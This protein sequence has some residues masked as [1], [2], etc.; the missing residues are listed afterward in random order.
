MDESNIHGLSG[1]V[2]FGNTCYMNTAIQCVCHIPK[3]RDYFIKKTF[4]KDINREKEEIN[5]IIEWYKLLNGLWGQNCVI[6]PNTFRQEVR[7]LAFKQ[8]VNLNLVGNGQN[9][10]QEFILFL[11]SS[12]HNGLSKK[13]SMNITGKI[14]NDLDRMAL[15]AFKS[16]KLFFKDD[17][18]FLVEMFYGQHTSQIYSLD[19]KLLSTTYEPFCYLTL[20]IPDIVN[21]NKNIEIEDCLEQYTKYEKLEGDNKWF[22]E[23]T[24][25]YIE[26]YKQIKFWSCPKVL[27]IVLKRFQNNG[28]KNT[29]CINFPLDNLDLSKYCLGYGANKFKYKL[30]SISNHM[31]SLSGGH[32]F[33]YCLNPTDDK[34]YL[35]NDQIVKEIDKQ[36]LISDKAYC[37]FY[38]R[39]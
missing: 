16:W 32:Y 7:V 19:K 30:R 3:F 22:H 20:P 27:I 12:L 2:N 39:K 17:Y 5:F 36:K 23:E 6:S 13:V 34:W 15:E 21:P 1:L 35:F 9:D 10:V 14:V 18:S 38:E 24:K 31:G 26:C 8:G 33:S 37:L 29:T 4:G 11:I 25:E 28:S